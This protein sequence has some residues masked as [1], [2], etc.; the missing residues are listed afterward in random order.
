MLTASSEIPVLGDER[1]LVP[2][3]ITRGVGSGRLPRTVRLQKE[4][5]IFVGE[6]TAFPSVE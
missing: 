3:E 1:T 4:I 6:L 2:P 5:E